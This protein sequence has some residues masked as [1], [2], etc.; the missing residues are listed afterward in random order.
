M[1]HNADSFGLCFGLCRYVIE[2]NKYLS[3]FHVVK[4]VSLQAIALSSAH[5][6]GQLSLHYIP[7]AP[8]VWG[9]LFWCNNALTVYI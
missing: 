5:M 4:T 2:H 8:V 6:K 9:N 1:A 3:T 7:E